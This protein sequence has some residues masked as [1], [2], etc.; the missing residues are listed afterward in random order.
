MNCRPCGPTGEDRAAQR[1]HVWIDT[2][3]S[4]SGLADG[5]FGRQTPRALLRRSSSCQATSSATVFSKFSSSHSARRICSGVKFLCHKSNSAGNS[6]GIGVQWSASFPTSFE[7]QISRWFWM[8]IGARAGEFVRNLG[9]VPRRL[10]P[11]V[12]RFK[13]PSCGSVVEIKIPDQNGGRANGRQASSVMINRFH[14]RDNE[15]RSLRHLRISRQF[16]QPSPPGRW[17]LGGSHAHQPARS[18]NLRC[19]SVVAN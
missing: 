7:P 8:R 16:M 18:R 12:V 5:D 10:T 3:P 17:F 6:A 1:A 4:L 11:L 19:R 14:T 13:E 2:K 15:V 9:L